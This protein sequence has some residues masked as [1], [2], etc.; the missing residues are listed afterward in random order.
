VPCAIKQV[1][2]G[3]DERRAYDAVARRLSGSEALD[4]V[5]SRVFSGGFAVL[6]LDGATNLRA[7]IAAG[8]VDARAVR[9]HC[10]ESYRTFVLEENEA[11]ERELAALPGPWPAEFDYAGYLASAT[12]TL[13]EAAGVQATHTRPGEWARLVEL[14]IPRRPR[15]ALFYD[16]KPANF[17]AV[18]AEL[19]ASGLPG[20]RVYK[21]DFDWML[22]RAPVSHQFVLALLM[23]PIDPSSSAP[24]RSLA[25]LLERAIA[26][27]EPFG[28][29]RREVEF[30]AAYHLYR[31]F[32]KSVRRF[33]RGGGAEDREESASLLPYLL[34]ALERARGF[35]AVARRLVE[36]AA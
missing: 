7:A 9:E 8:V 29:T 18:R 35:P 25:G 34:A 15:T 28:A 14:A 26:C 17:V 5:P 22:V 32:A 21:V 2:L 24:A 23:H 1:P 31:N 33:R 11:L 10:L 13:A 12:A 6:Y 19:G 20:A 4:C 36:A 3:P 30:M 16:P 27:S